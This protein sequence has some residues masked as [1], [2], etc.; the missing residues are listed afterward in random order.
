[1]IVVAYAVGAGLMIA[2]AIGG[3]AS[4]TALFPFAIW[5]TVLAVVGML[6]NLW[7]RSTLKRVVADIRRAESVLAAGL[8]EAPRADVAELIGELRVLGFEMLG[9]TDTAIGGGP[10]IRTWILTERAGTGTTWIEVGIAR[11]PIAI[12]LSRAGDGRFLETSYPFGETIDH[13][14]VYARPIETGL[15]DALGGH[16]AELAEWTSRAG[17][18]L[19]VRSLDEYRE[20][21][22]ELR[23]RTGGMRVAAYVE[24]VVEPNL[25]RWAI[26]AAIGFVT[27]L[28]LLVLQANRA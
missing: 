19:V 13:P 18:P 2:A 7:R 6:L 27:L 9:A 16:R 21:E 8:V 5:G 11:K 15:E 12:F 14:D 20:V 10:P 26:S 4:A 17:P 24:R 28:A 23:E 1:V 3:A 25:R 22:I